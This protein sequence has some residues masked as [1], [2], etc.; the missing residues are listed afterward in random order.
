MGLLNKLVEKLNEELNGTNSNMNSPTRNISQM[1]AQHQEQQF[2]EST[3]KSNKYGDVKKCPACGA[4][5]KSFSTN[6]PDCGHEFRN[7]AAN[8][9]IQRLFEMLNELEESSK[10]DSS[11]IIG[12]IG[13]FYGEALS[14]NFGGTKD[15]RRRKAIVQ[16][17]P[18]P[19]T[20]N[21]ILEFL[22]Q[23]VPLAKR[24]SL[25]N[26]DE[27]AREMYPV[28]K[29]KCEQIIMK[30]KFSMQEDKKT[31]EMIK[32]YADELKIKM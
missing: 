12:S 4:M 24:P 10:E 23:A 27:M 15:M 29:N 14:K 13:R 20:K 18:I 28:W 31:L 30:A 17:F 2:V 9:S 11:S 1:S 26:T 32:Q 25:F 8:S 21:D 5:I 19:T 3:L 22:S 16:N 7:I 6:C